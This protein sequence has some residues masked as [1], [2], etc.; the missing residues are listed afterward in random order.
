MSD[1]LVPPETPLAPLEQLFQ[2]ADLPEYQLPGELATL[3]GGPFGLPSSLLYSNFVTSLDGVAVVGPSSGSKLSGN[4][5]ADR[6]VM[7]L[8]RACSEAILIGSGT[9]SGSPGHVWTAEHIFPPQAGAYRELRRRLG[10][11]ERPT[12]VIASSSGKVD[13]GHPGLA[14]PALLLT[15][16][17]GRERLVEAGRH[18]VVV[19]GPGPELDP[20][21]M[22]EAVRRAGHRLI[23]T[24]GG[25]R[26]MG[27]LLGA[28]QVDQLFLTVSPLLAGRPER[29]RRAGFVD[30]VD[31]LEGERSAWLSLLS[32]RRHG[33]HLF[34]RYLV[35]GG[36]AGGR[37]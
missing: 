8:L 18:Q 26:L 7:G 10:L 19:V 25:P 33:S 20:T 22:V 28:G 37:G 27:Q 35:E 30:G 17:L 12:L 4:S 2:S 1:S 21:R 3:Y 34:L 36:Q 29:E 9:L 11:S 6:F 32:A 16:E 15:S 24:E 13:L 31:L 14:H 5:Q 23:L